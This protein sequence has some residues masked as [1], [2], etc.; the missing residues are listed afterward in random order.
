M[1]EYEKAIDALHRM[2][3]EGR[4][5]VFSQ[6]AVSTHAAHMTTGKTLTDFCAAIIALEKTTRS[7]S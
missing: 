2:A 7:G 1:I 6:S 4:G 5:P 3:S